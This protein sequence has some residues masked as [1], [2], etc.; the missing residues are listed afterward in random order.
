MAV[1][2]ERRGV[3]ALATWVETCGQVTKPA[4][5]VRH[6][7][8]IP[9]L[10]AHEPVQ[11]KL[12]PE[13]GHFAP[14]WGSACP[15]LVREISSK[16]RTRAEHEHGL[17]QS[18]IGSGLIGQSMTDTLFVIRVAIEFVER[19]LEHW[20]FQQPG[21]LK[22]LNAGLRVLFALGT[23][24]RATDSTAWMLSAIEPAY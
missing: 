14:F 10:V 17:V 8:E 6:A 3:L 11:G 21:P 15:V 13:G 4:K 1:Q 19:F 20:M 12:V 16:G 7:A 18:D 5:H 9:E 24:T 23:I 2:K 22:R